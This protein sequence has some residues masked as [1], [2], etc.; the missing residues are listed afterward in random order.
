MNLR[1]VFLIGILM[2]I[3]CAC[4]DSNDEAGTTNTI[5]DRNI[6]MNRW[7]YSQMRHHYLW[8]DEL[9]DSSSLNYAQ[10]LGDFFAELKSTHD[11]FSYF[12]SNMG[13]N[14]NVQTRTIS[15]PHEVSDTIYHFAN[16]NIGY[17]LYTQYAERENLLPA[18]R[19][20][21]IANVD[22]LIIDLRYN[23]GGSVQTAVFLSSCLIPEDYRGTPAQ[24]LVYNKTVNREKF[25]DENGYTVYHFIPKDELRGCDLTLSRM[26]FLVG[27]NTAS[28]AESTIKMIEPYM[29]V[30]LIGEPTVGKGVGMYTISDPSY[31]YQLVPITFRYYNAQWETIPDEGLEPDYIVTPTYPNNVKQL[32]NVSEPLLSK[33]IE[34]IT[35]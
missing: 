23:H 6:A 16:H 22:E 17:I 9:P 26:F 35:E 25:G 7:V 29:P 13:Y 20:M 3:V 32:G 12:E 5:L 24:Y 15:Y 33:A 31:P 10:N 34:L 19:Q 21:K 11:R 28:A 4:H 30:V 1:I 27:A 14:P 2:F 18:L 8:A